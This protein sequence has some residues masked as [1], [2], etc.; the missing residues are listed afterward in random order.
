MQLEKEPS[1]NKIFFPICERVLF[2][3]IKLLFGSLICLQ[4]IVQRCRSQLRTHADYRNIIFTDNLHEQRYGHPCPKLSVNLHTHSREQNR[5]WKAN[6][7]AAS[8]Q[9]P[10]IVGKPEVH[11]RICNSPPPLPVQSQINP[12]HALI[13]GP[14][15]SLKVHFNIILQFTPMSTNWPPI[16][17]LPHENYVCTSHLPIRATCLATLILLDLIIRIILK[18][19]KNPGPANRR[20]LGR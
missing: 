15:Y 2:P 3:F 19:T 12:V 14:F 13:P 7:F 6:R 11:Y 10:R 4:N 18:G 9:M 17:R 20:S 5:S 16:L 8:H 1:I